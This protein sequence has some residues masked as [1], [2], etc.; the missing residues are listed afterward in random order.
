MLNIRKAFSNKFYEVNQNIK[1]N[2]KL[3]SELFMKFSSLEQDLKNLDDKLIKQLG[4]ECKLNEILKQTNEI[5]LLENKI[6]NNEQILKD[7]LSNLLSNINKTNKIIDEFKYTNLEYID[8]K[9]KMN[10]NKKNLLLIGFYGASNLGDELMLETLLEQINSLGEFN[11]TIMLSENVEYD[12]TKLPKCNIIHYP[13]NLLDINVLADCFDVFI[14][15][16]GA[17]ID[18]YKY[19][20]NYQMS[21][22]HIL[23]NLS[24]RAITYNK[25]VLLY[26][27][28]S[29]FSFNDEEYIK[30]L[31]MI[32]NGNVQFSLRDNNSL[33]TLK[34]FNINVDKIKLVHDIVLSNSYLMKFNKNVNNNS[35]KIK[36]GLIYIC[37][38]NN[39]LKL[40][41]ITKGIIKSLNNYDYDLNFIPFYEYTNNDTKYYQKIIEEI[42]NE[43][44]NLKNFPNSFQETIDVLNNQDIIISMRYHGTLLSGILNKKTINIIFDEHRHYKNKCNY[45]KEK[46]KIDDGT[47]N[48]SEI[49]S[50]SIEKLLLTLIKNKK[51]ENNYDEVLKEANEQIKKALSL[52]LMEEENEKN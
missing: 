36:I 4:F 28:S 8:L 51:K 20:V 1:K 42:G 50:Q 44:L 48:F 37:N 2:E 14:F 31:R 3:I 35:K 41:D 38:E 43:K 10:V 26:G 45:L 21:L 16:G 25:K 19:N 40:V 7:L 47:I 22:G 24:L 9:S 5:K 52:V 17:I 27:L 29:N 23:V 46:Y 15:G 33:E 49:D 13:Q 18:D 12:I 6:D 39:Y 11:I 32:S 30:K 34:K